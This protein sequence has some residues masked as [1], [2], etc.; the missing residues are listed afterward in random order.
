MQ[1]PPSFSAMARRPPIPLKRPQLIDVNRKSNVVGCVRKI[2]GDVQ[3]NQ[4]TKTA[5]KMKQEFEMEWEIELTGSEGSRII[6]KD[7]EGIRVIKER[8]ATQMMIS[9][10]KGN[11]KQK[12]VIRGQSKQVDLA[13]LMV[14]DIL[15][16]VGKDVV[17]DIQDKEVGLLLSGHMLSDIQKKTNTMILIRGNKGDEQR[18]VEIKGTDANKA[19]AW[20]MVKQ[21][22]MNS[23][24]VVGVL[25]NNEVGLLLSG[26]MLSDIQK[27]TNTVILIRGKKG[28]EQ[29]SVEMKGTRE[30]TTVA[31]L[32]VKK[33]IAGKSA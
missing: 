18:P 14:K 33:I 19:E 12:L 23:K 11:I 25:Q 32:M 26:H 5:S 8:T 6:G 17:G 7:G 15:E 30:N 10:T 20:L 27:K 24:D 3:A 22:I 28:D 29:R 1:N 13:I 9:G 31:W 2:S 16:G 4:V 21:I